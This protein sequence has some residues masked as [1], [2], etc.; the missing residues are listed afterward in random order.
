VA[1]KNGARV[2]AATRV[3]ARLGKAPVEGRGQ[4]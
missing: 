2:A 4:C 3:V 1:G